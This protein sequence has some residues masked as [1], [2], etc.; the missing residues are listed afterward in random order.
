MRRLMLLAGALALAF[1]VVVPVVAAAEGDLPHSGRVLV[2]VKG[3]ASVP[4]GEQADVLVVVQG[5]A[6]VGG[7]VNTVVVV[8]G[9]ATLNGATVENL[10]IVTGHAVLGPGTTILSDVRTLNAT[11]DQQAGAVVQGTIRGVERDLANFGLVLGPALLLFFLGFVLATIVVGLALVA[12]GT[13]QIRTAA[14]LVRREPAMT[15]LWGLVAIFVPPILA[16]LLMVT[17]IG[18]PLGLGILLFAWPLLAYIGYLFAGVM[19]GDWIVTRMRAPAPPAER[20]YLGAV[21]GLLLIQVLSIFPPIAFIVSFIGVGA[22]LQLAWRTIR[23]RPR[24]AEAVPTS[25]GTGVQQ[26]G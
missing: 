22:V 4:A 10:V 17:V 8:D 16:V 23:G 3:D 15:V 12:I 7:T 14:E 5:N 21:V 20:P 19:L 25:W 24:P 2:S 6:T 11:V 13:R 18:V 1:L 9:T 26:A